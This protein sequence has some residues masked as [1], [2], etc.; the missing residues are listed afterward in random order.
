MRFYHSSIQTVFALV[1]PSN[2]ASHSDQA[3]RCGDGLATGLTLQWRQRE[4]VCVWTKTVCAGVREISKLCQI[5]I[6]ATRR[7]QMECT[8][9]GCS[10]R[11][12]GGAGSRTAMP[13]KERRPTITAAE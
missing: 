11:E 4:Q 5:D 7:A 10:T 6:A 1:G 8:Q 2:S 9:Y 13:S 12:H 3:L